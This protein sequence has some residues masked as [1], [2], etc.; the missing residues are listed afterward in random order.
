MGSMKKNTAK[1]TLLI[2]IFLEILV[3]VYYVLPAPVFAGNCEI[4]S[5]WTYTEK[6][7]VIASEWHVGITHMKLKTEVYPC[8]SITIR[9]T[10][11]LKKSSKNINITAT[12]T[13]KSKATKKFDCPEKT[14]NP[15]DEYSCTVC[16]ETQS[17]IDDLSCRFR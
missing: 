13:D 1:E 7:K 6:Q 15:E 16:F 11:W 17:S 5:S 14:L 4:I 3:I 9:N 2:T 10:D 8:A 12:F